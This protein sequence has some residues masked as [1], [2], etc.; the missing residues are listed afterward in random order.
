[1]FCL[2]FSQSLRSGRKSRGTPGQLG[3]KTCIAP[4]RR[5]EKRRRREEKRRRRGGGGGGKEK[6]NVEENVEEKGPR[7]PVEERGKK[8]E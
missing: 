3:S 4:K 7:G 8:R 5:E 2:W 6:E 1:M